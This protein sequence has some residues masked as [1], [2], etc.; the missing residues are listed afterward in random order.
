M[1]NLKNLNCMLLAAA[2][3]LAC[4]DTPITPIVPGTNDKGTISRHFEAVLDL[5]RNSG[6]ALDQLPNLLQQVSYQGQGTSNMMSNVTMQA[7]HFEEFVTAFEDGNFMVQDGEFQLQGDE[8]GIFGSYRGH[9]SRSSTNFQLTL[10]FRISGGTGQFLMA[11]GD[12]K[13]TII[14]PNGG[15][16][17]ATGPWQA[18][19]TGD[20]KLMRQFAKGPI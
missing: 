15:P 19:I 18:V 10:S 1:N 17:K 3:L 5:Q 12:L 16:P 7:T 6:F 14:D 9:G 2:I 13:V 4:E 20:V 11:K 8:D